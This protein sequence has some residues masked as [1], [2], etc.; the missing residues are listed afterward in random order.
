[1]VLMME[2]TIRI[3]YGKKVDYRPEVL[4]IEQNTT[5]KAVTN[6]EGV[7]FNSTTIEIKYE[8][9][10]LY[11]GLKGYTEILYR[12][13]NYYPYV[14][15]TLVDN[16][17]DSLEFREPDDTFSSVNQKHL[18][19][20]QSN[21]FNWKYEI[22][23][24][25]HLELG[26]SSEPLESDVI[27]VATIGL[28]MGKKWT[29][30]SRP[31]VL[32]NTTA[33][34]VTNLEGVAI[35]SR[36]IEIKYEIPTL[37]LGLKG[38]TEILILYRDILDYSVDYRR[39]RL[40]TLEFREPDDTFS[41]VNQKHLLTV[42][43]NWFNHKFEIKVKVHLELGGSS[44][45]DVIQVETPDVGARFLR[46]GW[47]R[48]YNY[49]SMANYVPPTNTR[50]TFAPAT[51]A[52]VTRPIQPAA[53]LIPAPR[54]PQVQPLQS[55][56]PTLPA[57]NPVALPAINRPVI[58]PINTD[59]NNMLLMPLQ[60]TGPMPTISNLDVQCGK[61]SMVVTVVFTQVF[62]GVIY[63]KGFHTRKECTFVQL[64]SGQ[65]S[66]TFTLVL[67]QCGTQFIDELGS[68]GQAYLENTIIIQMQE[69][70]QEVWDIS[71]QIRCLW[72]GQL[73]KTVS[74]LFGVDELDSQIVSFSG[75]TVNAFMDIQIGK[76][77]LAPSTNG[78]VR[79][80]ETM[81][82][83]ISVIGD[84]GFD[85]HFGRKKRSL[86]YN[87]ATL[88]SDPVRLARRLRVFAPA[89]VTFAD[90]RSTI[91]LTTGELKR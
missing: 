38:Y 12:R 41:S 39:A 90:G 55:A 46:T 4:E 26:G 89:D 69:E 83:V 54:P 32:E 85:I 56:L 78:L 45:S 73:D 28:S 1:M 88:V 11:L 33:K 13:I 58:Q 29:S 77:P 67:D 51:F 87:K 49:V 61:E 47:Y 75:D 17:F 80:G 81:T 34:A 7:A 27:Q 19:T 65:A 25:V 9:P 50:P 74:A 15:W 91:T 42:E 2:V 31:E 22:K 52:P 8:I 18:L 5:A 60:P 21:W 72:E 36:T 71:R 68:G 16:A 70:I 86:Q 53:P 37:Y 10:T 82:M 63:A 76:G 64:N 59:P 43:S 44:E 84:P 30:L 23:V 3:E 35:N 66:Y 40:W 24:K 62:S 20:V 57:T 14:P 48:W 6:L 79:I